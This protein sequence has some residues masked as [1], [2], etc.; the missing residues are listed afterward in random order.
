M[1]A[2]LSGCTAHPSCSYPFNF[3]PESLIN[4]MSLK[5]SNITSP[6]EDV[7]S[8]FTSEEEVREHVNEEVV[9]N[10]L[11]VEA[12]MSADKDK[13]EVPSSKEQMD[14]VI[15]LLRTLVSQQKEG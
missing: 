13:G 12:K 7:S 10:N 11:T 6:L 14:Q 9:S 8:D 4:S 15:S 2:A 1:G 5:L 3:N